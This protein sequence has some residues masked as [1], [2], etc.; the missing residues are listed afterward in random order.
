MK[1]EQNQPYVPV[2]SNAPLRGLA[3]TP[4]STRLDPAFSPSLLNCVIRDGEVRR[5]GGYQQIGQ[6]LMGRVLAMTEFGELNENKELVVLTSKRQY[7][8]D[9][10][11]NYFEDL[12]PDRVS[13]TILANPTDDSIS[14][15]TD[16]TATFVAG[17]EFPIVG[18]VNEGV[19]TT[20]SSSFG[21]GNTTIVVEETLPDE[22]TVAG[23]VVLADEWETEERAF[24]DF[25]SLT[26][27]NG[28]HLLITNGTDT[29]RVW[30]GDT[31]TDF[32]D[33]APNFTDLV[34]FTTCAV[35]N[36]HLFLGG[37]T[38]TGSEEQMTIAWS[39]AGDFT[40]FEEGQAGLQILY[41]LDRIIALEVLGD[42]LAI[43]SPDAVMTSVYVGGSIVFAFELVIPA[44]TRH[45]GGNSIT[46]INVG[47]IYASQENFY[48]FDGTRGLR[49][50]GDAIYSDYKGRKDHENLHRI[51]ALNDYAKRT[52]YWAVP[53]LNGGTMIYTV[54][55]DVFDLSR[56]S[57][58][59]EKYSVNPTAWGFFTNHTIELTWDDAQWEPDEMPWEDELGAWA[60]EAEQ[61]EFPIRCFGTDEGYV[62]LATE[63]VL[64]DD[65]VAAE[66][67]YQTMDFSIPQAFHS[68]LGRWGEIE[69]EALGNTVDV[70]YST[71]LGSNWTSVETTTLSS[72]YTAYR[73]PIDASARTM[74]VRFSTFGYFKL[75]WCR[76]WVRPGG[77]R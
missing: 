19:Y 5:R 42:R 37:V 31:L 16:L 9:V 26:D 7:Y 55:Y 54:E 6:R 59:R 4:A 72:S 12:T 44:G 34:S 40:E 2:E 52:L 3:T 58:A 61:L 60:E 47:H 69:F 76:L 14:I 46:N 48:L 27:V 67:T 10:A 25:A 63:G 77:P 22:L 56:L 30:D 49:V 43:Y 28:H 62:F 17:F 73:L 64:T 41:Q 36:E 68:Q 66:Q 20:V 24:I 50:L 21:G 11:N 15:A 1:L 75:R 29:P 32:G 71:D 45:V 74:R 57:W 70:A 33:W 8:Y 38:T 35:F 18:G 13:H 51:C 53:D 39:D 23:A 65:G